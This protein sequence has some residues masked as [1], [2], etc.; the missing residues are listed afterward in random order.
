MSPNLIADLTFATGA[1]ISSDGTAVQNEDGSWR[2]DFTGQSGAVLLNLS[3]ALDPSH[4][5][6]VTAEVDG[7]PHNFHATLN[8]TGFSQASIG[9]PPNLWAPGVYDVTLFEQSSNGA[10]VRFSANA[11]GPAWSLLVPSVVDLD[12]SS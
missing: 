8:Q 9:A 2:I 3:R 5:I 1:V 6:Q 11:N 10:T 12:A 7:S 4:R